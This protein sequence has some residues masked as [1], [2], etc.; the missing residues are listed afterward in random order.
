MA[1]KYQ[2]LLNEYL[3]DTEAELIE[4]LDMLKANL[5]AGKQILA[6][7][8]KYPNADFAYIEESVFEHE[9]FL[10]VHS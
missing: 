6:N 7:P 1:R 5:K 8:S 3:L 4:R 10:L 2:F 9:G